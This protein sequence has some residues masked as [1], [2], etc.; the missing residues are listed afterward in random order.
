LVHSQSNGDTLI[1][2]EMSAIFLATADIKFLDARMDEDRE[3]SEMTLALAAMA[4]RALPDRELSGDAMQTNCP[5]VFVNQALFSMTGFPAADLCGPANPLLTDPRARA[6]L[7][8]LCAG[9]A[10]AVI[11]LPRDDGVNCRLRL[12]P[13]CAADGTLTHL[14]GV[15]D[16]PGVGAGPADCGHAGHAIAPIFCA[17]WDE[18]TGL[19]S[20][21]ALRAR[22]AQILAHDDA[23]ALLCIGFDALGPL[24]EQLGY[25]GAD[26]LLAAV[27]QRLHRCV[28]P[29]GILARR[30]CHDFV[31]LCPLATGASVSV[32]AGQVLAALAAP[33]SVGGQPGG[34]L[35]LQCSLGAH[36]IQ[37]HARIGSAC[38]PEDGANPD[39]L[40]ERAEMALADA[41]Q[42][43]S[44]RYASYHAEMGARALALRSMHDALQV[45][46][47]TDNWDLTYQPMAD[48]Q[49]GS[50]CGLAAVVRWPHPELGLLDAEQFM[51]VADQTALSREVGKSVLRRL[52]SDMRDW[53]NQGLMLLPVTLSL[54]AGQFA[55]R[56]LAVWLGDALQELAVAADLLNVQVSEAALMQDPAASAHMLDQ[57]KALG[58]SRTLDTSGADHVALSHL[59]HLPL[60]SVSIG[61]ALIAHLLPE[62]HHAVL[63]RTIVDCAHQAGLK[64]MASGVDNEDQCDFLR[65]NMCDQVQGAVP[66]TEQ[67]AAGVVTL[68]REGRLLP[69]HL[70]RIQ[71][72]SRTLLLVDDEQNIVAALKRLLRPDGYRILTAGSGREGLE[73][74]AAHGVDVIVSDQRMPGMLGADFLRAAKGLYPDTIRIMLSGY[75]ELQSVTDAVN[76]GAIYK[77][78]T[79][80][81]DDDSL[82]GH[83]AEAFRMKE[84]SDENERLNLALRTANHEMARTNRCME[85]LL[86]QNQQQITRGETSLNIARELLE[87]MPLPVIG[88][89]QEGI[90]AF[91]NTAAELVFHNV[92]ILGSEA[93]YALP[94]LFAGGALGQDGR[95]A[96]LDGQRY[97][98][99]IHPMGARSASRGSLITLSVCRDAS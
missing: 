97:R 84:T 7:D 8:A 42:S 98:V 76:E 73:V 65:R 25:S 80:P 17:G 64:V 49:L 10:G 96:E 50:L 81:W 85:E 18:V 35:P 6:A 56:T 2:V 54:T 41:R 27:A 23:L 94:Q 47:A 67:D 95:V 87:H 89:D 51:T 57:L 26:Q 74:L 88:V 4:R 13:L 71:Q 28:G 68:L 38:A 1:W 83:I 14:L 16:V 40:L 59:K 21:A 43:Q 48:L 22:L 20:R 55:D 12:V 39:R 82:R 24:L 66:G 92:A 29:G 30:G 53:Q 69:A 78:L 19:P 37:L 5:V 86:R 79:K 90:V 72:R 15:A 70:L 11:D 33:F 63:A 62:G 36:D 44:R 58:V 61:A 75:T 32:I 9:G 31:L 34:A 91:V 3:S 45:A 77:F 93:Q 60:D 52:L 46:A 99:A